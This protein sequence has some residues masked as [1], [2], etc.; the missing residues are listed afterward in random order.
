MESDRRVKSGKV[1]S[2]ESEE[3]KM[4]SVFPDLHKEAF[5]ETPGIDSAEGP[6]KE[7][8]E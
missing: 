3:R 5:A 6:I 1:L 7:N 4:P 8:S 2:A